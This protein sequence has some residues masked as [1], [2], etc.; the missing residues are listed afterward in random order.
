MSKNTKEAREAAW[1]EYCAKQSLDPTVG[2]G[3]YFDL[4]F[5][6][7]IRHASEVDAELVD[8]ITALIRDWPLPNTSRG[9]VEIVLHARSIVLAEGEGDR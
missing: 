7:G 5:D 3:M 2:A 1:L 8:R 4:G 9:F 6:A